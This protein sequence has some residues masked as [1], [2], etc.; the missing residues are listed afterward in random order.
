MNESFA[1]PASHVC[2]MKTE[3]CFLAQKVNDMQI[4]IQIVDQ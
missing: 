3:M 4:S 1:E 2:E